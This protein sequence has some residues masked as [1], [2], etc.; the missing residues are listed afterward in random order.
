MIKLIKVK[1]EEI[2]IELWNRLIEEFFL[3]PETTEMYISATAD[4][5]CDQVY[6]VAKKGGE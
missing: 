4:A 5:W 6:F 1:Q 3:P 2:C